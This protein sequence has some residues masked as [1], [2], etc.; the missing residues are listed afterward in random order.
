MFARFTEQAHEAMTLANS[1]STRLGHPWL[2]TEHL[3]LGLLRQGETSTGA[4]LEGLG[5]TGQEVE[6][7]IRKILGEPH[8]RFPDE[9]D[10]RALSALGIDLREV[11]ARVEEAFGPG[12]LERS[13]PGQCGVPVMP[14]LKQGLER[15]ARE[16]GARLIETDHLLLGTIQVRG[17]LAVEVLGRLGTTPDLI[18]A[19]VLA[20]RAKAS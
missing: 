10:E 5:I 6:A 14:R 15:A 4:V 8:E 20:R 2:G 16:A 3:L 11:R 19:S 18:R 1:E 12:A 13:R 7:E 17:A 9:E